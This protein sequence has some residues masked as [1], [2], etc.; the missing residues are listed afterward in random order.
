MNASTGNV[1]K[2]F[3]ALDLGTGRTG[4][5]GTVDLGTGDLGTGGTVDENNNDSKSNDYSFWSTKTITG[6]P[7]TSLDGSF[8]GN[9]PDGKFGTSVI[10]N[11]S[12]RHFR[13]TNCDALLG[14]YSKPEISFSRHPS[15]Y[16]RQVVL[17]HRAVQPQLS[18]RVPCFGMTWNANANSLSNLVSFG[19]DVNRNIVSRPSWMSRPSSSSPPSPPSSVPSIPSVP[20]AP[21]MKSVE[22]YYVTKMNGERIFKPKASYAS[23]LVE[24][25]A[26]RRLELDRPKRIHVSNIPFWMTENDLLILFKDYG[27]V[28]EVQV[29]TN[30]KGSKV[31]LSHYLLLLL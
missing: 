1:T 12:G 29:I 10:G 8:S 20:S 22:N 13:P 25:P 11:N 18:A 21:S 9:V 2:L 16:Q 31:S 23:T 6:V 7:D 5:L 15:Q 26:G 3:R 4:D 27:T 17:S 28:Q 19:F 24:N 14:P 30:E